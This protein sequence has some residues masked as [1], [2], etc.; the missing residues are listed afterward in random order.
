MRWSL[1]SL[2][3]DLLFDLLNDVDKQRLTSM[4]SYMFKLYINII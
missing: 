4:S 1:V 2:L 3:I